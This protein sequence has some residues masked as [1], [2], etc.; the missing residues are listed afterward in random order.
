MKLNCLITNTEIVESVKSAIIGIADSLLDMDLKPSFN[1]VYKM[2][3]S[4]GLE[5]DAES[6][7]ALYTEVLSEYES[8]LITTEEE[9]SDIVGKSIVQQQKEI[10][11]RIN[12]N[13]REVT[14]SKIGELSPEKSIANKIGKLFD[15]FTNGKYPAKTKSTMKA[16]EDLLMKSIQSK[17]PKM[18]SS[19]A[20]SITSA[21][22]YFF[23]QE[24]DGF[25][26][27]D[28]AMNN[29]ATLHEAVKVEVA[30]YVRELSSRLDN[31]ED[32]DLL[33]DNWNTYTDSV[34][35]SMYE[36]ML[37][38]GE[39]NKLLNEA[40]KQIEI[41]GESIIDEKGN[42][43]W[44]KLSTSG[45]VNVVK[46]ALSNLFQ[47]GIKL[48][49]GTTQKYTKEQSERIANFIGKK[50]SEKLQ[51]YIQRQATNERMKYKSTDNLAS[52]FLKDSG[53]FGIGK[54]DGVLGIT[55]SD[56]TSFIS[57]VKSKISGNANVEDV[58]GEV[59][60]VFRDFL[61]SKN[62]DP[63]TPANE[64]MP[65]SVIDEKVKEFSKL[66]VSKF[67]PA[68]ATPNALQRLAAFGQLNN[69]KAF[70]ESTQQA[71]NKLSGVDGISQST[72]NRLNSLSNLVNS[73]MTN[74][75]LN[76]PG[77][78]SPSTSRGAY[79]LQALAQIERE[80]KMIIRDAKNDKSKV[81][82][83]LGLI[84]DYMS[85]A[86]V[87]LLV[88]PNNTR[89]N[90][91][92]A[93]ASAMT[94]AVK[95]FV[96]NPSLA[97]KSQGG[98]SK[99]FWNAFFS[100][101]KG[102]AHTSVMTDEDLSIEL[103]GGEVYTFQNA[104]RNVEQSKNKPKAI[105]NEIVRT[106]LYLFNTMNRILLN[107]F[108]A[109]FNAVILRRQMMGTMYQSLLDNGYDKN[110]A[111]KTIDEAL[112]ISPE[113]RKEIDDE[114]KII[115]NEMRKMGIK[116]T[117]SDKSLL[118]IEM[119]N[120]QY[121]VALQ[122]YNKNNYT[123]QQISEATKAVLKSAGEVSKILTGKKKIDSKDI[124]SNIIYSIP[125][126][127][128]KF[129]QNQ[130]DKA[131]IS[132]G[133]GNYRK[134]AYQQFIGEFF[135]KNG[136]AKFA[137]GVGNFANLSL[138][139]FP[140]IGLS[141]TL[142][143]RARMRQYLFENKQVDKINMA[144]NSDKMSKY[145][146][147]QST[148]HS[149]VARQMVSTLLMSAL[150]ASFVFDDDKE[151]GWFDEMMANLSK[152]KS[153]QREI[154]KQMP[155]QVAIASIFAYDSYDKKAGSKFNRLIDMMLTVVGKG[156][157]GGD[158]LQEDI[159][160]AKN[161]KDVSV[162]VGKYLGSVWNGNINQMEQITKTSHV[163]QSAFD[164]DYVKIVKRDEAISK[165]VYED[166]DDFASA[167]MGNGILSTIMRMIDEKQKVDRYSK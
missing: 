23:T 72:L 13:E 82:G 87:S 113:I 115:D 58:L 55:K 147:L 63:N 48:S 66:V 74:P 102:G 132:E 148:Y 34:M 136:V 12:G 144:Q 114:I 38:K 155:L 18:P 86:T 3:K 140:I 9:I 67:A 91:F 75:V 129:Q 122:K 96:I 121:E 94:E 89:E 43:K 24:K 90:I 84:N 79:A 99:I 106:P 19:E 167:F 159:K 49:D 60:K 33:I 112:N 6:I 14:E 162:A 61:V 161:A 27:L 46:K 4:E 116:M 160:K 135:G 108:D 145:Y 117:T 164:K 131:R 53:Y 25:R 133:E 111:F 103:A 130:F 30:N 88:N 127:L 2:L 36:L 124:I 95:Q 105:L 158:Y 146:E 83:T 134:A 141:Q 56:W 152:T 126:F 50:Y 107:S 40:L 143:A 35:N 142:G 1:N 10:V 71:I 100:H 149:L 138:S 118:A 123:N 151:E 8:D 125:Q 81:V 120:A 57:K 80:V 137:G 109:A 64:K 101:I 78:T 70:N 39:Q 17:L 77:A 41:N 37:G 20:K 44:S 97:I 59:E 157:G 47:K 92:T 104:V 69:G 119:R 11:D 128:L 54:K 68:T 28:G 110:E 85:M 32:K 165:S 156:N 62:N 153:G 76:N 139:S 51:A 166:M 15:V 26:T 7:G 73:V 52:D 98:N 163:L 150:I 5:V 16:F 42:V 21:L 93:F 31:K 29:L 22:D 45:D 154:A 65:D